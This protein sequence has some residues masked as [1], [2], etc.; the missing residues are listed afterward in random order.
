MRLTTRASI[1][2]ATLL[3][4]ICG[5]A[6]AEE[7]RKTTYHYGVPEGWRTEVIPFPL[8]FAPELS[9]TGLEDIR[10]APGMFKAEAEDHFSY[11][12]LWWINNDAKLT[13]QVLERDMHLY[14]KGLIDVVA[15]EKKM[16]INA[17]SHKASFKAGPKG[18]AYDFVGTVATL[19]PFAT[20]KPI[21]LNVKIK[22]TRCKGEDKLAVLFELSPQAYTAPIWPQLQKVTEGFRCKK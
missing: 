7:A 1:A 18:G 10:F 5:F 8:G 21:T 3:L 22:S 17:V 4:L 12:F 9:Y 16:D 14:F 19:D 2:L 20:E 6:A 15:K 11:T 13:L